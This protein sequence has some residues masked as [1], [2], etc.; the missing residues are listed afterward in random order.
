MPDFRNPVIFQ[1]IRP[2]LLWMVLGLILGVAVG[3]LLQDLTDP[4]YDAKG[5]FLI[6][7]LPFGKQQEAANDPE[8]ERQI[9]QSLIES[10]AG[11]GMHHEVARLLG[12]SDGDVAFAD[13]DLSLKLARGK[14]TANIDVSA[15]RNSRLGNVTVESCD[16]EF[17]VK[18][19]KAVFEKMAILN[20]IAGRLRQI[21]FRLTLNQTEAASVVQELSSISADRIK[22]QHQNDMLEAFLGQKG[23]LENFPA[24]DADATLSN[25][26][27]Q[28]ILVQSEYAAM[29]AQ[30]SSGERLLGKKGELDNLRTQIRTYTDSLAK[31]LHASLKITQERETSLRDHLAQVQ[32]QNSQLEG[33]RAALYEGFGDFT[34]RDDI[35]LDGDRSD[36]EMSV[37]VVVDR[38]YAVA[39]P[40]RP[41]LSVNLAL[42]IVFGMGLGLFISTVLQVM[43]PRAVV[44]EE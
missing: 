27:T 41:V 21:E 31:A 36:Q 23:E 25:L 22:Y 15:S 2:H 28:M 5:S 17:A 1:T 42:G 33:F 34:L 11:E 3:F 39:K 24:F 8:T 29:A 38:A 43:R 44:D 10:A 14:L 7:Q 18:V 12:V 32:K 16:K 6:N 30:S 9:V 13:H 37:I 40:V 26:K 4:V 35:T 19:V 20:K